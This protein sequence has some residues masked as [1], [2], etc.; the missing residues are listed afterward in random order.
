MGFGIRVLEDA[1]KETLENKFKH[2]KE[3]GGSFPL[4]IRILSGGGIRWESGFGFWGHACLC[5]SRGASRAQQRRERGKS[6]ATFV[7][8]FRL[9]QPRF[10]KRGVDEMW[11]PISYV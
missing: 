11:K 6:E 9:P 10:S 7:S 5:L 4:G 2:K 3:C 8:T 1:N